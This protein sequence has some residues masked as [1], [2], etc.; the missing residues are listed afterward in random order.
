MTCI[1]DGLELEEIGMIPWLVHVPG[2]ELTLQLNSSIQTSDLGM[3]EESVF[4]S[5]DSNQSHKIMNTLL[6]VRQRMEMEGSEEV[7]QAR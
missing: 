3:M 7:S 4:G 6:Y 1:M 5:L 2:K